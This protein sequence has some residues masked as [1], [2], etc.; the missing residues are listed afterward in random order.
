M[1]GIGAL[2][3]TAKRA[4]A[5]PAEPGDRV[6]AKTGIHW[7]PSLT[8]YLRGEK[9]TIPENVGLGFSE[10]P[11]HTHDDSG[12]IHLEFP[13]IVRAKDTRLSEFF[14]IWDK[15]LTPTCIFDTCNGP[16]GKV[17]MTV[18]GQPNTEFGDFE[19]HDGDKIEIRFE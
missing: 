15:T 5:T 11:I 18:N 10:Q 9:Q 6:L 4:P 3:W 1:A 17:S 13:G 19:M 2:I 14:R 16:D 7:H 12:T 8:I